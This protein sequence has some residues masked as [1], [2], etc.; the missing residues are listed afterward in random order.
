MPA[1]SSR[2]RRS[3][4]SSKRPRIPIRRVF[5]PPCPI[6][7]GRGAGY[8]NSRIVPEPWNL[9]T[10]CSFGPRCPEFEPA[11]EAAVPPA[12][13]LARGHRAACIHAGAGPFERPLLQPTSRP[14]FD[15][16]G[17]RLFVIPRPSRGRRRFIHLASRPH[18]G[19]GGRIRLR[20][21]HDGPAG[22]RACCPAAGEIRLQ[23]EALPA[24]GSLRWREMRRSCRWSTRI[25]W[26]RCTGVA[27]G[28]QVVGPGDPRHWR[29]GRA[30]RPG[31]GDPAVSRPAGAPLRPLSA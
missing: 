25:R 31:D 8:G 2:M 16:R 13:E 4:R 29:G 12:I 21:D 19:P 18:P 1:A 17:S 23:G 15:P 24:A 3:T 7:K 11:C 10:G 20:Q 26:R 22:A 9:P 6:W 28:R 14:P 5:S 30:A 27:V